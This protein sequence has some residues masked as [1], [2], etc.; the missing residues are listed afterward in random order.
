[1]T[2]IK[3]AILDGEFDL[4]HASGKLEFGQ[5]RMNV[6]NDSADVG[7][8]NNHAHGTLCAGIVGA[9]ELIADWPDGG[10]A[11]GVRMLPVS[12]YRTEEAAPGAQLQDLVD[13]INAAVDEQCAVI[14]ISLSG[15]PPASSLIDAIEKAERNNTVIVAGT[16]NRRADEPDRADFVQYPARFATVLGVGAATLDES[17]GQPALN[18]ISTTLSSNA[19]EPQAAWESRYGAGLD[20]VAPG[21]DVTSTDISD[22][23]GANNVESPEGD[24]WIGFSG[25]SAATPLVAGFAALIANSGIR[26]PG[27]IR[28][29]I[30]LAAD[31]IGPGLYTKERNGILWNRRVGFG[32]IDREVI[33]Q[34]PLGN[35][36]EGDGAL[37]DSGNVS[38]SI[39]ECAV[40][41]EISEFVG[42]EGYEF[43]G[44]F[45]D[46]LRP[47]SDFLTVLG[48]TDPKC[49]K[50]A[51]RFWQDPYRTARIAGLPWHAAVLLG[52]GDWRAVYQAVDVEMHRV[53]N[54]GGP[55]PIWVRAR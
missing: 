17:G 44:M 16:G 33:K 18:R 3:V 46:A 52:Q 20:V 12:V 2:Q 36:D 35:E 8:V 34:W 21:L 32:W 48:S 25:T 22:T 9:E 28:Q 37:S 7:I 43:A 27:S 40:D 51:A 49:C 10:I 13:G 47:V 14:S 39:V 24:V 5:P 26:S 54:P 1:M 42:V 38:E 53:E 41:E 50:M 55:G 23:G 15:F 19:V 11:P 30:R 45:E 31:Q 6:T 29:Q 4:N